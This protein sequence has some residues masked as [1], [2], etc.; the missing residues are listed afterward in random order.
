MLTFLSGWKDSNLRPPAPKAGALTGLRY[1]PIAL[2]AF[3]LRVQSYDIFFN[4]Q[5]F[6]Y[7]F[8]K[9]FRKQAIFRKFVGIWKLQ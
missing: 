5:N 3:Q 9:N 7:F 1:A 6:L 4:L 2:A 8:L